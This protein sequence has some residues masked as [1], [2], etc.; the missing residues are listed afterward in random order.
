MSTQSTPT[1]VPSSAAC[2]D[3]LPLAATWST[4]PACGYY[5]LNTDPALGIVALTAGCPSG[6]H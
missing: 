4:C 3:S 1:T 5:S 2:R 6:Q